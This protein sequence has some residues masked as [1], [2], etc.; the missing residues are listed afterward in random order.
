MDDLCSA[1]EEHDEILVR[2]DKKMVKTGDSI[3]DFAAEIAR[4]RLILAVIS[5]KSLRSDWCMVHELLQAFRRRNFD[6]NEFSSDVLALILED[7]Q[8]DIDDNS[9][10]IQHWTDAMNKKRKPLELADHDRKLSPDSWLLVDQ[11]EELRGRLP[12]MILALN[13]RAMPRGYE[14]ISQ[15]DFIKIRALVLERLEEKGIASEISP[16]RVSGQNIK[17]EDPPSSRDLHFLALALRRQHQRSGD[18]S[19]PMYSWQ[20]YLKKPSDRHYEPLSLPK[21]LELGPYVLASSQQTD[22][23]PS[24][25]GLAAPRSVADLLQAAIEWVQSKRFI[26]LIEIFVPVE[27]LDFDWGGLQVFDKRRPSSPPVQLVKIV[28]FALRSL[29]RYENELFTGSLPWMERKYAHLSDGSGLWLAG[30]EATSVDKLSEA[31]AYE[32]LVGIKRIT[33]LAEDQSHLMQWLEAMV[34][35]MVPVALWRRN[36]VP[37]RTKP[38]LLAHLDRYEGILAGHNNGDP[39]SSVCAHLERLP[40]RRREMIADQLVHDFVFLLDHP[41]RAPGLDVAQSPIISV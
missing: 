34:A 23:S 13:T 26:A 38:K 5:K 6:K 19:E 37:N 20:A 40:M 27:L 33:P 28:P 30:S 3:E 22:L 2:R 36:G 39:V 35:T 7:A 17:N 15:Q 21:A 25:S 31:E 11:M 24:A 12:D 9:D 14:A 8:S 10:L 18:S 4:G 41:E 16:S 1:L 29:E 32:K